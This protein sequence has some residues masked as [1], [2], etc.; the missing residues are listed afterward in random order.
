MTEPRFSYPVVLDLTGRRAVVIGGGAVALRKAQA[1]ADA[2]AEVTVVSPELLPEFHDDKRLRCLEQPYSARQVF[3][4]NLVIA[5]TD[6]PNVNTRVGID[7]RAAGALVNVVDRP[8]SCD[9]I[10]PAV[11]ERGPLQV[12]ISTGGAAPSLA[13]RIRDRLQDEFGPEYELLLTALAEVRERYKARPM[14]P[15]VRRRIF[16]RLTE[17]DILEAARQGPEALRAAIDAAIAGVLGEGQK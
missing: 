14:M 16:E 8:G 15:G 2:G 5:A 10:V 4:A 6:D 9:F 13:R 7:S 17:D 11:L 12:A 3:H 1:L